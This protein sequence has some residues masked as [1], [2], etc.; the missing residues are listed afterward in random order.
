MSTR[1]QVYWDPED[2]S[3]E[4]L[5]KS[6]HA[7]REYE[8]TKVTTTVGIKGSALPFDTLRVLMGAA[9]AVGAELKI[10]LTG[11]FSDNGNQLR[12]FGPGQIE[13]SVVDQ[14]TLSDLVG[15]K[16]E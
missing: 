10:T 8:P 13:L 4:K 5:E 12:L 15:T 14:G 9:T 11:T 7:M 6:I 3:M 2:L 16:E 1:I